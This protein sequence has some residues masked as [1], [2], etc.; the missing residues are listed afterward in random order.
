MIVDIRVALAEG[1]SID[2]MQKAVDDIV[3]HKLDGMDQIRQNLINGVL[4]VY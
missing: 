2:G 1:G 3:H 4:S